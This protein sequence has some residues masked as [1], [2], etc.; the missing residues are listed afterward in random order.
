MTARLMFRLLPMQVLLASASAVNG[1]I[2]G[3]F[4]SN[5]VGETAMSAVGLY[6]PLHTFAGALSTMLVGGA[7]ILSAQYMGRN[8]REKTQEV[9]SLAV[10]LSALTAVTVTVLMLVTG[11]YRHGSII[12]KDPVLQ[13]LFRQYLLGS[14]AGIP[15]YFLGSQFAAFLSLENRTSRTTAASLIYIAVNII[16][17]YVFLVVLRTGVFGL[18][19]AGSLGLWVFCLVQAEYFLAGRGELKLQAGKK[20]WQEAG[21]VIRIGA[22]GAMSYGYQALRG[23]LIN[24]L[25]LGYIGHAG[26]SAFTAVNSTLNLFWAIP[27]GMLAVSRM[28]MNVS[29]GE[30][31]RQTLADTMRTAMYRFVPV[32]CAVVAGIAL[33]AVPL[34][35]MYYRDAADPVYMYT[36]MGYRILPLCMPLSIILMHFNCY[37]QASGRELPVH[38]LAL[39]DGVVCTVGYTA[40]LIPVIGMSSVYVSNILNGITTTLVIFLYAVYRNR[41][42]PRN[43]EE[44]MVI[45]ED[46]GVPEEERMDLTVHSMEEVVTVSGNVQRFCLERGLDERR[47]YYAGLFLEE[48]AGNVVDHGFTKDN[49]PHSADIRV[50]HKDEGVILRIKDDCVPFDPSERRAITDPDDITKNIGIRMVYSMA[51]DIT[52]RNILGMN[53]LTIRI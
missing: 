42:L 15:A 49:R 24:A 33:C 21:S 25:I 11:M 5:S 26:L 23:I 3:L 27:T 6:A 39:L 44:V 10:G 28:M 9:F 29:I 18:A 22:P 12:T 52:Y 36:V 43:M 37:W 46:F 40:L 34:T 51:E 31:D 1:I 19:L 4:A 2:T 7:V 38:V 50:V 30:E 20:V 16:L 53:V 32:M 8:M 45:P 41:H 14:C 48:M 13:P 47:S 35:R 17:D